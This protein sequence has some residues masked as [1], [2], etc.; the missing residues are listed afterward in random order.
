MIVV[1]YVG[2]VQLRL[3][4]SIFLSPIQGVTVQLSTIPLD[5]IT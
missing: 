4:C 5:M 3:N 1:Y 2:N